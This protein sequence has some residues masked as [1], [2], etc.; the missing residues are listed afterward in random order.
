MIYLYEQYDRGKWRPFENGL[1]RNALRKAMQRRFDAG[2]G[3]LR[4]FWERRSRSLIMWAVIAPCCFLSAWLLLWRASV[5]HL[6]FDYVVAAGALLLSIA[7]HLMNWLCAIHCTQL[8][9]QA[10]VE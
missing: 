2:P 10:L 1:D 7:A 6:E 5:S 8:D 4:D 3:Y 9:R